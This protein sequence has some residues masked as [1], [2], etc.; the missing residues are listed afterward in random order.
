[1]NI[2][3]FNKFTEAIL[4]G[5][6]SNIRYDKT[7]LDPRQPEWTLHTS[8]ST[9]L[10]VV[11][12]PNVTVPKSH[13][14]LSNLWRRQIWMKCFVRKEPKQWVFLKWC[15]ILSLLC[16]NMQSLHMYITSG[17]N[18]SYR[19][20][21]SCCTFF[22]IL[23][24]DWSFNIL[25]TLPPSPIL[26]TCAGHHNFVDLITHYIRWTRQF[27]S[28]SVTSRFSFLFYTFFFYYY[29]YYYYYY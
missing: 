20:L 5:L 26:T 23:S 13:L 28:K 25:K 7:P 29:Y 11:N 9:M 1:M 18:N 17:L 2:W 15:L 4:K 24:V 10:N 19:S 21:S 14:A 16:I 27:C 22:R 12:F 3:R 8:D 6:Q